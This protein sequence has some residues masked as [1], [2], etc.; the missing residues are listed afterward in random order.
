M[1]NETV[2]KKVKLVV[3]FPK[4]F[5]TTDNLQE[6]H[7]TAK[8]ITLRF[9]LQ[10]EIDA[11]K[12]VSI[13]TLKKDIGRPQLVFTKTPVLNETLIKAQSNGVMLNELYSTQAV[14]AI[15]IRN[16]KTAVID[17]TSTEVSTVNTTADTT[18]SVVANA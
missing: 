11:K 12:I 8:N 10:K 17:A 4:G 6:T 2:T 18:T 1:K 7:P 15:K 14:E 5:F 3:N 16:P 9:R 13:G